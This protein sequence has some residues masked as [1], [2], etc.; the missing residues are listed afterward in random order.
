MPVIA[1]PCNSAHRLPVNILTPDLD[2][3]TSTEAA[4]RAEKAGRKSTD[5]QRCAGA[6]SPDPRN[7]SAVHN[8]TE[9]EARRAPQ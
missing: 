6:V 3:P 8:D 2:G 9:P 5:N 4:G 1:Q 7:A